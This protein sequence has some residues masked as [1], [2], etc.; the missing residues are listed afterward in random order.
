LLPDPD[1]LHLGIDGL[2]IWVEQGPAPDQLVM[3]QPNG[4]GVFEDLAAASSVARRHR[5]VLA[6]A[7]D[8]LLLPLVDLPEGSLGLTQWREADMT[9]LEAGASS[10]VA[11]ARVLSRRLTQIRGVRVATSNRFGRRI[12]LI[13]PEEPML[14][15][16]GLRRAGAEGG[17]VLPGLPG[18]LAVT[19][20]W[21]HTRAQLEA[22]ADALAAILA[23]R[24]PDP[25]PV[26]VLDH[27]PRKRQ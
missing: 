15:L 18:G 13:V 26:D 23:D 20:G 1:S 24:V 19:V 22:Y 14:V 7:V 2:T 17:M 3:S 5:A 21:W 16:E 25:I 12:P 11:S 10:S 9:A 6:V 4:W 27:P 8:P